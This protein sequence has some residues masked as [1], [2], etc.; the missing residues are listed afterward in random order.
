M[1]SALT[2][3]GRFAILRTS[4][5][6][7]GVAKWQT[8]WTQNP[9]PF[10]GMWVR[11]PPPAPSP[12]V[13]EYRGGAVAGGLSIRTSGGYLSWLESLV[14]TQNVGSSSLSPPTIY[15]L[16]ARGKLSF[17]DLFQMD[18]MPAVRKVRCTLSLVTATLES[19]DYDTD[20]G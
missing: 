2:S 18:C 1:E 16:Y 20:I 4:F 14:Y 17:S 19:G 11:V 6:S 9:P 8:Q 13:N 10:K 3:G 12:S 15:I 5:T 7:A